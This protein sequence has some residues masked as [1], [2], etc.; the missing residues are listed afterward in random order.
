MY[1]DSFEDEQTLKIYQTANTL[2]NQI[3]QFVENKVMLEVNKVE[4]KQKRYKMD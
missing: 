3:C 2:Y 1:N 4:F